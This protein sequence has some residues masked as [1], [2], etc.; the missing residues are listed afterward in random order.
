M[1]RQRRRHPQTPPPPQ[2]HLP[3]LVTPVMNAS[4]SGARLAGGTD[5]V[6]P[7]TPSHVCRSLRSLRGGTGV[8]PRAPP[9]VPR[10]R[11][12]APAGSPA[13]RLARE[14]RRLD[15]HEGPRKRPLDSVTSAGLVGA[16]P[17]RHFVRRRVVASP[18][19][20]LGGSPW[21]PGT[22]PYPLVPPLPVLSEFSRTTSFPR[23]GDCSG[24][25]GWAVSRR[26]SDSAPPE[27]SARTTESS[28]PRSSGT[29]MVSSIGSACRAR[30]YAPSTSSCEST[31]S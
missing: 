16:L 29:V 13:A 24:P 9:W 19:R 23:Y 25:C 12:L 22:R 17:A 30:T 28:R 21:V 10:L 2:R 5:G 7:R 18:P 11:R 3:G 8:P 14:S 31:L 4:R 1:D 26:G 20:W 27:D 15:Q 6:P